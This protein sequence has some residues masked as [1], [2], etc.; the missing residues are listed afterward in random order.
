MDCLPVAIFGQI[1]FIAK[2][3]LIPKYSDYSISKVLV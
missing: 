1:Y 3:S 2:D